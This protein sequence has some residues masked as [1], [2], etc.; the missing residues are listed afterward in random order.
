MDTKCM[1]IER[2]LGLLFDWAIFIDFLLSIY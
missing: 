2:W 1:E